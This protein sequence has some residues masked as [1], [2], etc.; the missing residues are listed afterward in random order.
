MR[1]RTWDL[2]VRGEGGFALRLGLS[3]GVGL[4][5]SA[6]SVRGALV[7]N[8]VL[9]DPAGPDAGNEWIELLNTGPWPVPLEGVTLEFG[10]GSGPARWTSIW[11]GP[12]EEE[13]SP[14]QFVTIGGPFEDRPPTYA[15]EL[16]LQNGPDALALRAS[17]ILLDL[18]GWGDHQHAEYYEGAPAAGTGGGKSLARL[19]DGADHDLNRDDFGVEQPSPGRAN[20]PAVDLAI[21]LR[22]AGRALPIPAR[23]E[24]I[25]LQFGLENRGRTGV[26]TDLTVTSFEPPLLSAPPRWPDRLDPGE[27]VFLSG[28]FALPA[29]ADSG[30]F[31]ALVIHPEDGAS[32][33][34]R[35]TV[36]L[37]RGAP[38]VRFTELAPRPDSGGAEWIELEGNGHGFAIEDARG[39][40][41]V[42]ESVPARPRWLVSEDAALHPELAA[43]W[44]GEWPSQN[45]HAASGAAADTLFLL[46][47]LG[48]IVDWAAYGSS[49]RGASWVRHTEVDAGAGLD[50]W[51]ET[52]APTPGEFEPVKPSILPR[53][54]AWSAAA[55]SVEGAPGGAWLRLGAEFFPA[56]WQARILDLEGRLVWSVGGETRDRVEQWAHWDARDVGGRLSPAGVYLV[57]LEVR[58]EAAVRRERRSLVLGR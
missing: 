14:G 47:P 16:H 10:D 48:R 44:E 5:L 39:T 18:V 12:E 26:T 24:G 25:E 1:W 9:Y 20:H 7:I 38:P 35:D 2:L 33:N 21:V 41:L 11:N 37:F 58:G 4:F 34:N 57:E 54:G 3:A 55:F 40:R 17:G 36:D 32:E 31:R 15:A 45:D 23:A 51:V 29:A 46:D 56:Q 42:L 43:T 22:R 19:V 6:A 13:L 8:E 30:L 49:K 27:R 50:A 52:Q 28:L 53:E